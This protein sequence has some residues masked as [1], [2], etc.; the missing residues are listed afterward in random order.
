[1]TLKKIGC[2]FYVILSFVQCFIATSEFKLE[3]QSGNVKFGSKSAIFFVRVTLKFDRWHWKVIG[4]LFY[5]TLSFVHY[6]VAICEFKLESQYENVQSC[7]KSAIFCPCDIVIW[8]MTL[9]KNR[10]PLLC[11][12]KLDAVFNSQQW[13]QTAVTVRK[14]Q[15]QRFVLSVW[16]WNLT[17]DIESP[18]LL[19]A[20]CIISWPHAAY[21]NWSNG[22]GKI[23]FWPLWPWLLVSDLDLLHGHHFWQS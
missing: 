1:M 7:S 12:F 23:E 21:S 2:L 15:I 8:Q 5:V 16:H 19:Q 11:Y 13:I 14:R 17:Y 6:F 10:T 9:K 22:N 3:L 18:M 4:H 20:L